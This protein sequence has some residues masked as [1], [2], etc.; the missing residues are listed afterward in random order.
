MR[1]AGVV[2]PRDGSVEASIDRFGG[3]YRSF[4]L[5]SVEGDEACKAACVGDNKCRAW[6]YARRGYVG[7][8]RALFFEKGYQAAAA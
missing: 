6:T 7:K 2:E 1:G 8:E 4:E 5:K 3:D